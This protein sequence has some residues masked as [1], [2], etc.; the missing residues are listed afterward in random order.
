MIVAIVIIVATGASTAMRTATT[1]TT[2]R[3][4]DRATSTA[5]NFPLAIEGRGYYSCNSNMGRSLGAFN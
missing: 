4:T 1:M 2:G 3:A 5:T